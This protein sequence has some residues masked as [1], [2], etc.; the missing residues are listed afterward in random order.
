VTS[1]P[2]P[3][4]GTYGLIGDTRTAALVSAG[5]SIDWLCFPRFD[6]PPLFGRLVGG[7]RAGR[8]AIEL[9]EVRETDR[10]YLDGSVVLETTW[11]TAT[12]EGRLLEGM[13]VDT[14]TS[15][16]P[17]ALVVRTLSCRQGSVRGSVIFD[18]RFDW[19][20]PPERSQR[21]HGRLFCTWDST[22]ATLASTPDLSIEPGRPCA[23]SLRPGESLT[24]VLGLDHR[25]PAALVDPEGAIADLHRTDS[26][27]RG[28][29][30][31]LR[32]LAEGTDEAVR[33]SLL[34]LR[35]LTYAPSGAPVAAPTT[36]LP[37]IP[38]GDAN[39]D[40]RFAWIR[41]ASMQVAAFLEAGSFDEPR[42][43]LWWMLH[44][45]RR[46]TP[47]LRV[48]YDVMGGEN[49]RE[50]ELQ[51]L[52][53]YRGARPVRVGNAAAEQFQLDVYGWMID[54]GWGHMRE[55]G[56][57]YRETWRELA[58]HADLLADRWHEPDNGIWELR[59]GR[60]HYV[61][62]KVMAWIGLDRALRIGERLGMSERRRRRWLDARDATADA[63]RRLG[64]NED[65]GSYTQSFGSQELDAA[66]L[67]MPIARI[68]PRDSPRVGG[69]I[70]AVARGLD[71]GY[72]LL[73][74][75]GPTGEGAFLPCSFW[76]SRALIETGRIAEG[77]EVFDAACALA[78]DLGLF[79][80]E[81][82]PTTREHTGNFPQAFTHAALV[83]AAA[84]LGRA[85]SVRA[86]GTSRGSLRT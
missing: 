23:L 20:R 45:S 85:E 22:V 58:G 55:T 61:H 47:E 13:V 9:D 53:G 26:W 15:L 31:G 4:I 29:S 68:E 14:N 43:F 63:V 76:W 11:V 34:T 69:T 73:Y 41:D 21:K 86:T 17:Q 19:T 52:P 83:E 44:A 84:A 75:F 81:M 77:R 50:R 35:L 80:E 39:W 79:A 48:V 8:F 57:L 37:E 36:S 40:Y 46:T 62:S 7:E 54:A 6:S 78:N 24:V 10:R 28:W 66:L 5:G 67:A 38:G 82:D 25:E 60:H 56:E 65:I 16:L 64:F 51:D 32:S 74:R 2:V 27:W 42:A 72:P 59:G 12:G 70:D 33:R 1:A 49:L 3:S 30:A 18:P 71:A